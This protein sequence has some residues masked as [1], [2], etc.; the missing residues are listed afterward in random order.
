MLDIYS[1]MIYNSYI[2]KNKKNMEDKMINIIINAINKRKADKAKRLKKKLTTIITK[3][4][5]G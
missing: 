2:I 4:R 3:D 5:R 1:I